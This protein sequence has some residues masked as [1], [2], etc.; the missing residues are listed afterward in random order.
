[1][2]YFS[3]LSD[4]VTCNLSAIL[5]REGDPRAALE[6]IIREMEEGLAGARRSVATAEAAAER[7]RRE[8]QEHRTALDRWTDKAKEALVGGRDEQARQA[9]FRKQETADLIAGI[10]QQ[11]QAAVATREHLTTTQRALEARLAEAR[12][13][14]TALDSAGTSAV[15]ETMAPATIDKSR[16]EQVEA[17]LESLRRDLAR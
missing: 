13:K 12:R 2:S 8:L 3:R 16:A 15:D 10:E 11:F 17:E 5:A 4:I 7:T 14:L 9:L 1:M 6:G